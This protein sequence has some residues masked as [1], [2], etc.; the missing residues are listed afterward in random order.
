[1]IPERLTRLLVLAPVTAVI[2]LAFTAT[3]SAAVVESCSGGSGLV[4]SALVAGDGDQC[5]TS[6]Y[7]WETIAGDVASVPDDTVDPDESAF[8]SSGKEDD[9]SGWDFGSSNVNDKVNLY[10]SWAFSETIGTDLFLYLAFQ[11]QAPNNPANASANVD[12]ELNQASA[13]DPD[14]FVTNPQGEKVIKRQGNGI[15]DATPDDLLFVYDW[16]GNDDIALQICRWAEGPDDATT[17]GVDEGWLK[18]TWNCE[19]LAGNE[20]E[21]EVNDG[22]DIT[23]SLPGA[24]TTGGVILRREFGEASFN[25]T[26]ALDIGTDE[27]VSFGAFHT[28]T[29]ESGSLSANLVDLIP[30]APVTVSN[31]GTLIVEKQ[32]SDDA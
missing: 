1:M 16:K 3:A 15:D 28:R 5:G 10:G 31:C 26:K 21:G 2:A 11:R 32:T 13:A 30:P 27:C 17:A 7:D 12:F 6:E 24:K 4:S 29:R 22:G 14:S 19:A 18:G 23:S 20:A 9:T 8:V 25:L